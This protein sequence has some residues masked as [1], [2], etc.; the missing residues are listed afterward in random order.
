[1]NGVHSEQM[2]ARWHSGLAGAGERRGGAMGRG[3]LAA[4][5]QARFCLLARLSLPKCYSASQSAVCGLKTRC[6]S[7]AKATAGK[8]EVSAATPI[9]D[10]LEEWL[11][12]RCGGACAAGALPD[13]RALCAPA[14]E[15]AAASD[16]TDCARPG[17]SAMAGA[18][19]QSTSEVQALARPSR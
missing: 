13:A 1:M 7:G 3:A 16:S 14:R 2:G 8:G 6:R 17:R 19:Q 15:H 5:C 12:Q 10:A 9:A 4:L 18:R 11:S